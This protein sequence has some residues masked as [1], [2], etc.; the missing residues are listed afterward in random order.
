MINLYSNEIFY[1]TI[2][3]SVFSEQI[4][5]L[6]LYI[7]LIN[8]LSSYYMIYNPF[9]YA[10]Y[11]NDEHISTNKKRTKLSRETQITMRL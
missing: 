9:Y 1:Y 11:P 4:K 8:F 5:K 2:D 6:L 3:Q 10:N 7:S